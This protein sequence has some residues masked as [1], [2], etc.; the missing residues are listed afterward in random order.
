MCWRGQPWPHCRDFWITE[1]G[2]GYRLSQSGNPK[3]KSYHDRRSVVFELGHMFNLRNRSALGASISYRGISEPKLTLHPR[4]RYWFDRRWALDAAGGVVVAARDEEGLH[5][6]GYLARAGIN[7]GDWVA[8]NTSVEFMP[9]LDGGTEVTWLVD[10]RLAGYLGGG[11]G[12]VLV[13]GTVLL[14]VL[15]FALW[16]GD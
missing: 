9:L 13:T 16:S 5:T 2:F 6:P 10:S 11:S 15:L 3:R 1:T 8:V 7:Y 14:T 12:I 4:Y